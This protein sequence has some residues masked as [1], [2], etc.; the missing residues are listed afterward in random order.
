MGTNP[1]CMG[2]GVG[3]L[4]VGGGRWGGI[5]L[6]QTVEQ[7]SCVIVEAGWLFFLVVKLCL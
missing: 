7:S 2:L 3:G 1:G 5:W 4:S 6:A